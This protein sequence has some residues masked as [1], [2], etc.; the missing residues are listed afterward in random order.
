M[1]LANPGD[2]LLAEAPLPVVESRVTV[3]PPRGET[4]IEKRDGHVG[5]GLSDLWER[6]ELLFFLVWRDM[7]VRYK[8]TILGVAWALLQLGLWFVGYSLLWPAS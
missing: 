2:T 4:L 6:R 3:E 5:F 1:A 8:Q 7:K